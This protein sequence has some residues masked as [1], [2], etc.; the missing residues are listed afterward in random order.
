MGVIF[1]L[2]IVLVREIRVSFSWGLFECLEGC[3]INDILNSVKE[4]Y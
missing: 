1:I 3:M 4:V 2:V